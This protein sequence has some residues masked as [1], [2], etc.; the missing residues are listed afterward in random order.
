MGVG[1]R[2]KVRK[3]KLPFQKLPEDTAQEVTQNMRG[4]PAPCTGH[5]CCVSVWGDGPSECRRWVWS[6]LSS[7]QHRRSTDAVL[8]CKSA[9]LLACLYWLAYTT[10]GSLMISNWPNGINGIYRPGQLS[11]HFLQGS[12]CTSQYK[13]VLDGPKK[14]GI[15]CRISRLD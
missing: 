10:D 6:P 14:F 8:P 7:T 3:L 4:P 13:K 9:C 5:E 15:Y 11:A 2:W 12:F 1:H